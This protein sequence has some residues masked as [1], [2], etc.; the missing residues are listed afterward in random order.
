LC[1]IKLYYGL[2]TV[3]RGR[4]DAGHYSC[5]IRQEIFYEFILPVGANI[6]LYGIRMV[7]TINECPIKYAQCLPCIF[8]TSKYYGSYPEKAL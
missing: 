5:Y 6:W 3:S 8:S 7:S 4:S 1:R 2:R